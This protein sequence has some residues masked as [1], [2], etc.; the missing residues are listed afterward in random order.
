MSEAS[1]IQ[2]CY[3]SGVLL[4]ASNAW[5][6]FRVLRP[7]RRLSYQAEQIRQGDLMSFERHCGG[8]PE[9]RVLRR[10]MAGMSGHILRTQEQSS[11][12]ADRLADGQENERKRLAHELH[13]D[14]LQSLIAIN[15]SIDLARSWMRSDPDRAAEMLRL[16]REQAVESATNLRN[17]IGGLRP[18]ALDELGLVAALEMEA[19]K[20]RDVAVSVNVKGTQRRLDEAR[21]LALFRAAQEV[22]TNV[23]RHSG[24]G[25]V[26]IEVTYRSEAVLLTIADD[27]CGFVPPAHIGDLAQAKHYGLIGLQERIQNLGGSV[28]INST[29]GQGTKI[30]VALPLQESQ[31]PDHLVRDPVCSALLEPQQVYSSLTY[32]GET[33]YFCC[34]V[35][36]GAFQ[37][38]P[39]LYLVR[40]PHLKGCEGHPVT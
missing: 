4:V 13:D 39:L 26:D 14:T 25:M 38:D 8:I 34:P 22:L 29:V 20:A 1:L 33:Y 5:F 18:P 32:A 11:A 9:I 35:C 3:V 19:E 37:K 30:E 12:Y 24:A 28:H 7:L 16:A 2:L 36:Q 17:L 27:G 21:E 10:A 6:F 40:S 31:Q 23:R 15:Q